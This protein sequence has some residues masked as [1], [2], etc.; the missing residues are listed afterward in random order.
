MFDGLLL[1]VRLRCCRMEFNLRE[2]Q[3]SMIDRILTDTEKILKPFVA[4]DEARG[5]D[6]MA[7]FLDPRFSWGAS[8]SWCGKTST[9][10][11]ER[12]DVQLGVPCGSMMKR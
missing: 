1:C 5:H 3:N 9:R 12:A 8:S 11:L 6:V 2:I 4:F 7:T 10:T